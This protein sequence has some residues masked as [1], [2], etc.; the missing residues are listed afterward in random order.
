MTEITRYPHYHQ[1][2]NVVTNH[3]MVML[4]EL[5]RTSP[6]LLEKVINGLL[7][8]E[9][10]VGPRFTQ[11]ISGSDSVPDALI[12]QQPLAIYIETKIVSGFGL[13][14][15]ER[16]CKSI[17]TKG[18]AEKGRILLALTAGSADT[19]SAPA[20]ADLGSR[21]GLRV[22]HKTFADLVDQ[23]ME[24]QDKHP[25]ITE[26][27]EEFVAFIAAR[28][29]LPRRDQFMVTMLTG[30]SWQDNKA[31]GVYYEPAHRNAKW[32]HAAFLGLYHDKHISHV[33]RIVTVVEGYQTD[34]TWSFEKA[35]TG[36][37]TDA[38]LAAIS[39]VVAAAQ[40]Y[41]PGFQGDPHRYYVVDDFAE[42]RFLKDSPGGM[43][44]HRYFDIEKIAGSKAPP[45]AS[46]SVVAALLSG[47]LF[48]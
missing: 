9:L 40:Y 1:A 46:G 44:G 37:V 7:G 28:G 11:Q 12:L 21:Y 41:Y 13:E 42:T 32:Q 45:N 6:S 5:Y 8:E 39:R 33:G 14:Q 29:L 23:L 30:R 24:I 20:L 48:N 18:H 26:G 19:T 31:H 34:G 22:L 17:A 25:A 43:M 2:E 16:H 27:I 4:R 47:K 35:E 36:V 15:L 10:T 3:T 38:H